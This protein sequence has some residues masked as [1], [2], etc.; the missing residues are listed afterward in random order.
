[1]RLTVTTLGD[2]I[3][4]LDVSEDLE[5]ENFKAFCE[6]ESGIPAAEMAILFQGKPLENGTV[7]L[8]NHGLKEGDVVVIQKLQSS[9][10][11]R[12]PRSTPRSTGNTGLYN[13]L[14]TKQRQIQFPH[15]NIYFSHKKVLSLAWISARFKFLHRPGLPTRVAAL[16]R[17]EMKMTRPSFGTCFWPILTSLL[18]SNRTIHDWL[19]LFS[20]ETLV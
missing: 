19:T 13:F 20:A 5:L 2:D 9:N 7:S 8:K 15:L 4:N 11:V 16:P 17:E 3:F 14:F 18:N 12:A 10:F 6:V 1:M